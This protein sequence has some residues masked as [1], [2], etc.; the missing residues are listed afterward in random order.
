MAKEILNA[1]N[2]SSLENLKK[3]S[4]VEQQT[5]EAL[6]SLGQDA[7]KSFYTEDSEK[8]VVTYKM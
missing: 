4:W 5:E 8:K 1:N 6:N 2:E 7:E 3:V